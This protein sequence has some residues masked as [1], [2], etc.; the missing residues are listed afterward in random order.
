[1]SQIVAPFDM[2]R[3]PQPDA[4]I[5]S[6]F[7][8]EAAEPLSRRLAVVNPAGVELHNLPR[9][10]ARGDELFEARVEAAGEDDVSGE[11]QVFQVSA[12]AGHAVAENGLKAEARARLHPLRR[13]VEVLAVDGNREALLLLRG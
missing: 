13:L 2:R 8:A 12:G 1:M 5:F 6:L 9:L 4:M 3:P 10:A 11:L 7:I